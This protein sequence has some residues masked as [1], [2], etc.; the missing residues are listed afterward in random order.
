VLF[1][2]STAWAVSLKQLSGDVQLA[3]DHGHSSVSS[4]K[5]FFLTYPSLGMQTVMF[6]LS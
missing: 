1:V 4:Q 3:D 2:G 6:L 5:S